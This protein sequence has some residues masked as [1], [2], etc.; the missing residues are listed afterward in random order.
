MRGWLARRYR[1]LRGGAFRLRV[2]I[3]IGGVAALAIGLLYAAR[4]LGDYRRNVFVEIGGDLVGA[5]IVVAILTPLIARAR[6]G[7]IRERGRLDYDLF[8]DYVHAATSIVKILD[9]HSALFD[10]PVTDRAMRAFQKALDRQAR[11]QILLLHPNFTSAI[12]HAEEG[13]RA[14]IRAEIRRNVQVLGEFAGRLPEQTAKRFEVRLYSATAS[15]R[16][17]QWDDR[18][19]I[20]FLNIGRHIPGGQLETDMG[21]SLGQFVEQH[22]G[23]L[24]REAMPM[25]AYL[26]LPVRLTSSGDGTTHEF[27][28]PYVLVEDTHYLADPQVLAHLVT[29]HERGGTVTAKIATRPDDDFRLHVVDHHDVPFREQ[30]ATHFQEKYGW[31]GQ[32]FFSLQPIQQDQPEEVRR[33]RWKR[34]P[35][36]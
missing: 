5:I 27:S 33:P 6:Q 31:A 4:G 13:H 25:R 1:K 7:R 19:L 2:L 3:P 30:L 22:F 18:A 36:G 35:R 20:S 32:A 24:W 34:E 12:V 16:L 21:T 11:V 9:T 26:R 15:A 23:Q 17:Y 29:E 10:L 14:T 8:T 28:L